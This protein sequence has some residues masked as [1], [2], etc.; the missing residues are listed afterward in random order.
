MFESMNSPELSVICPAFNRG[1]LLDECVTSVFK[2]DAEKW[3]MIIIDDASTD[4][5]LNVVK[6]LMDRYSSDRIRYLRQPSNAGAP[7]ARNR[8][9][10]E[11]RGKMVLFMDSDDVAAPSGIK[12]LRLNLLERGLDYVYGSVQQTDGHLQP[13]LD[14]P[15]I[16][17]PFLPTPRA[18]ADLNWHTMGALYLKSFLVARVGDWNPQLTGSQDWEYQARV[19]IA[20]GRGEFIDTRVG[21]WRKH[22]GDRIGVKGYSSRYV[23]SVLL[24]CLSIEEHASTAGL[25]DHHLRRRLVRR[26]IN[27]MFEAIACGDRTL[28]ETIA[29]ECTRLARKMPFEFVLT[30]FGRMIPFPFV[31]KSLVR[32]IRH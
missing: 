3:E 14:H 18:I 1:H 25:L 10:H 11:A 19:K 31:G 30:G 4:N 23:H 13:L 26:L 8:G 20:A 2:E 29:A 12:K 16:G 7:S 15:D 5:T 28:A 6:A 22:D 17:S 32:L 9:L 24:A 21:Y 27:H